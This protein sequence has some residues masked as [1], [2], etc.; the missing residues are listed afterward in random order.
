MKTVFSTDKKCMGVEKYPKSIPNRIIPKVFE[1]FIDTFHWMGTREPFYQISKN[2]LALGHGWI[3]TPMY[4]VC[5]YVPMLELTFIK[6]PRVSH[7]F[8]WSS[9][10]QMRHR[11][12]ARITL[13]RLSELSH[14]PPQRATSSPAMELGWPAQGQGSKTKS[15]GQLM[16]SANRTY[17]GQIQQEMFP[18]H[19]SR[20]LHNPH[21]HPHYPN[22]DPPTPNSATPIPHPTPTPRSLET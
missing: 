9:L 8:W 17:I 7:I 4:D 6:G 2:A 14:T 11:L 5:D 10:H 22:Q 16:L 12:V 19:T 13:F 20:T 15:T 3:L 18:Y 21:P 1:W